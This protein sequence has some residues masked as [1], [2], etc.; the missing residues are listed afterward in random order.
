MTSDLLASELQQAWSAAG[1]LHH[2]DQSLAFGG[3]SSHSLRD[4]DQWYHHLWRV[5]CRLDL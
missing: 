4:V 1:L 2:P 3:E 5:D